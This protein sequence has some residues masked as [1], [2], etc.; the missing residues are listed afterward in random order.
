MKK[1]TLFFLCITFFCLFPISASAET[2]ICVPGDD[3][4][5]KYENAND[6]DIIQLSTEGTYI[7]TKLLAITIPK[8]ITVRA[9][10]G[11]TSRPVIQM[12]SAAEI[13][14]MLFYQLGTS[15]GTITFDG[16]TIDGNQKVGCFI[17]VKCS[18]GYNTDIVLNNCLVKNLMNTAVPSNILC[19]TYS[20]TAVNLNPD[21]LTLTNCVFDFVGQGVLWGSGAGRPKNV[22]VTNCLFKG[23]FV[24]GALSNASNS[25][26]DLYLIDHCTFDKNNARDLSLFGNAS[27]KNCIFSNSTTTGT[28]ANANA[29]GTG[30]N[31]MTKCGL[32]YSGAA[33]AAFPNAILDATTLR[34][35]PLLDINGFA[36]ASE[37]VDAGTDGKSIG[38]YEALGLTIDTNTAV[39]ELKYLKNVSVVQKGDV[40]TV[41]G[42]SDGNCSVYSMNGTKVF[43]EQIQHKT[44]ALTNIKQGIYL[45]RVNN[46]V[47]KFAV[48]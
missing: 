16:V 35:N 40:F 46:Q 13:N 7:W 26:V 5:L 10:A 9:A 3:I 31:L 44:I 2:I 1:T 29:F 24:K 18:S 15:S 17:A 48:R 20:N 14:F 39:K 19:F 11:L 42:L 25:L 21:N 28:G 43:E 12:Q 34:T 37:Y 45:M 38:F 32:Y 27:I 36:T 8:S 6:G 23:K 41:E 47:V 33:N 4:S 22:T 30:G